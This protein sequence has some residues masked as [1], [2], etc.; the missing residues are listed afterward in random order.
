MSVARGQEQ[1]KAELQAQRGRRRNTDRQR[2]GRRDL[3]G[4]GPLG[5]VSLLGM[6]V[7]MWG[8]GGAGGW[9]LS[10]QAPNRAPFWNITVQR[11][12]SWAVPPPR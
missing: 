2:Q 12:E 4:A 8:V 5:Q 11:G 1:V 10:A 6:C 9:S 3:K 7:C